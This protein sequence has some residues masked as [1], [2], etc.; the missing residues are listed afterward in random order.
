M[1][2]EF[3]NVN[4]AF[5]STS[6]VSTS[7]LDNVSFGIKDM[8]IMCV[9]G[10][11]GCGKSTII[12][13]AAGFISPDSGEVLMD[14][15]NISK[16]S[17]KRTVVFQDHAVFPWKTVR[18]NIE[19]GLQCAK[20]SQAEINKTVDYLLKKIGLESFANR[21]PQELSGGMRQRVALARAF[22]VK[23]EVILM[24]EP[25][26]SIDQQ[27]RDILQEELLKI[28]LELKQTIL[29][30]THNIEEAIFLGD[31]IALLSQRPAKIQEIIEVP[32]ARPRSPEIRND[33]KFI[34]LKNKIWL[35]LRQGV[36]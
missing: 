17:A 29:F 19:F 20:L 26:A 35:S 34:E 15:K 2:I 6:G 36:K 28:Q 13:L 16:P 4:K 24:D 11:S 1:K 33:K 32:F 12:N 31:R 8:E 25:F 27:T 10:P 3:K 21:Y 7:A 22:A 30:V 18:E 14:R 9:V 5:I 23:P